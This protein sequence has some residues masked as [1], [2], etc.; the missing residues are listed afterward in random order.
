MK[1]V[2][3]GAN[4]ANFRNGFESLVGTG[5]E[6]VDVS[7]GLD[8]PGE[9]DHF[10]S[11]DVIVGVRL[12]KAEPRPIKTRLYQ[13]PAAGTDG[14]DLACLPGACTLCNAFGHEA[15]IAEYVMAA[16]LSRHVPLARADERLR[17]GHWD[18]WAGRLGALR[19]EL[20]GQ[21]VGLLG[22][23]HIGKAVAVRAKAFGMRVI[24]CNR[25]PPIPSA[26]VDESHGLE[27][28]ETFMGRADAIVVSL[29]LTDATRGIV[30]AR[31]LGAMRPA[32]VI[33]N[34]GRGPVIDEQALYDTLAEGRIGGAVIDTW[35]RYPGPD[36]PSTTPSSL[37]FESLSNVVMTPHMSGW[38]E[39][40]IRRRQETITDNIGRLASGKQ[41]VNVVRPADGG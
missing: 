28:L 21:T 32:G 22:Y 31:A 15:A 25:T 9:R 41:L 38:T 23:G 7:E 34:V 8:R 35:Y 20:G 29:P 19:T 39:G 26:V 12:T 10:Q 24:V 36:V 5:H 17:L 4:A 27:A 30:S 3:H 11:A 6:I 16:M 37:P 1:I 13:A 18:Y 33:V 14:I 2:F 40:T